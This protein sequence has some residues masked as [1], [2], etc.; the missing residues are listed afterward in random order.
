MRYVMQNCVF[1]FSF[2]SEKDYSDPFNEVEV[3]V[4]FTDPDG[5]ERT[6]PAFWD[7]GNIWRVRYS[8]PRTGRH[9]FRTVSSDP[10]NSSLNNQ[11]GEL[12]VIPYEGDNPLFK[13]GPIRV[14][15]NRRYLE[16]IDGTPFFWLGD[17][18]WMGLCKRLSLPEDFQILTEDRVEKGFSVIQIV[19]GLYPDMPAFDPRGANEAGFPWEKDYSRINP[20]YFD[21]ADLRIGWLVRSGLVPC[22]VGGWGYHLPWMGIERMKKHWR[23]LVARYSAFPVVWCLAGEYD[24]P[25]YLSKD[26]EK[27]REFQREGWIGVGRYLREIDPFHRPIT[28]HP[29][30]F[31][32]DFTPIL[33]VIDFD[34][35]QTG[36]SDNSIGNTVFRVQQSYYGE[37][38]KPVVNGEVCYEGIG[39][40]CREQIQRLMFWATILNGACGYT[41]GANGIWQVNRKDKP[42]GPSP[43]GMSWGDT[44]WEVAYKLPGSKQLGIAKRL[45]ERYRWWKF[46][47]HPEWVEVEVSEENKKNHYHPYC[48]GIPGEVRIVYIPLFYNNFKIK[49]IEEGISY[50]AYL[51][52]PADGSEIDIGN[53]VPDGEGKWQLPE[54][55]EGSG[56]RLPIYQDWILVLEAR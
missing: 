41:Y 42:F 24:M 30:T 33:E 6:V 29:G 1:E 27:D 20:N 32:R 22:I 14:S 19:A 35:L 5:K 46:E 10:S 56:I 12:E 31:T 9:S 2:E 43:H 38:R 52:N 7:G 21:M 54:L 53:V 11:R 15:E 47:P 55:V 39:G 3:S 45:L 8:S 17:T 34:M 49:E 44:P 37:P 18:W 23:Y 28:V 4:I 26:K 40:Q 25:Y 50:R 36:H 51:F 16:H 13:H 48:A